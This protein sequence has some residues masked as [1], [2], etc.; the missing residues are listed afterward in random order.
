MTQNG[1]HVSVVV[2]VITV[3]LICINVNH[4]NK[5]NL[6]EFENCINSREK[7]MEDSKAELEAYRARKVALITGISGQVILLFYFRFDY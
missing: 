1:N 2:V 4:T 6:Q 5:F 7:T 3:F